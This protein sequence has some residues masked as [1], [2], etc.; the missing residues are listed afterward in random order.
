MRRDRRRSGRLTTSFFTGRDLKTASSHVRRALPCCTTACSR[1]TT[2][3]SPDQPRTARVLHISLAPTSF[4]SNCRITVIPCASAIYGSGSCTSRRDFYRGLPHLGGGSV[5]KLV[6][7]L[8]A[9]RYR[10][11][12]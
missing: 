8:F 3:N 10:K 7:V 6:F 5:C 2:W 12:I 9:R 11:L 1:R 4:Q